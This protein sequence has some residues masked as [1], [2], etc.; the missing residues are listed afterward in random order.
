M[1]RRWQLSAALAVVG[2]MFGG[3]SESFTVDRYP[4]FY[5]PGVKTV[6]VLPFSGP[7]EREQAGELLARHL[8]AALRANGTYRVLG[9]EEL[10]GRL[11]EEKLRE[12]AKASHERAAAAVRGLGKVQAFLAGTVLAY[13]AQGGRYF[14]P[15]YRW[16]YVGYGHG[17]HGRYSRLYDP[18]P[19]FYDYEYVSEA[20]VAAEATMVRAADGSVLAGTGGPVSA[21]VSRWGYTGAVPRGALNE[22]VATVVA[23]LVRRFAAVP[24]RV[25]V[26]PGEDLRTATGRSDGGWHLADRFGADAER[27]YV[28]LRLPPAAARN[29]FRLTVTPAGRDD[30]ILA[31]RKFTWQ[32]GETTRALEFSPKALA[33]AWIGPGKYRVEFLARGKRVMHRDFRIDRPR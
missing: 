24:V 31:E 10:R 28:V 12:L 14:R 25:E 3:C 6:A 15:R 2:A 5:D 22:S 26:R 13:E 16:A 27:M 18:W 9:P 30:R 19:D 33:G 23:E 29:T 7:P 11:G 32:P 4:D 20:V 17:I 1:G 8:A 21:G